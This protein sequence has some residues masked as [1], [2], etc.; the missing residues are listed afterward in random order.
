MPFLGKR[1]LSSFSRS[2]GLIAFLGF[3]ILVFL[4]ACGEK[5]GKSADSGGPPPPVV[6]AQVTPT[7]VPI[8]GEYVARTEA[9]QTV[10]IRSRVDG[11]LEKVLFQEGSQVNAGQLL[12]VIDQRPF[13]AA[14]QEARGSL[15]QVQASLRKAQRDVERFTPLV[16]EDA[17]PQQDLDNAKSAVEYNKASIDR[18]KAGIAKAELDLKF[19]E[20]R[21]PITGIIGKEEVTMGNLV[22]RDQTLL[23]TVSSWDPMRVVF[24]LSE[25]DYLRLSGTHRE[26]QIAFSA[27]Q[28]APFELLMADNAFYPLRGRLSFVDRALN[29]TTGTLKVYVSFPNPERRLRPGMFGRVRVMLEER[30]NALLVPQ[31][32]VQ[33]MQGVDSLLV[34][35]KDN[36]V[37]IRI[38]TLGERY[39]D[40]F[41]VTEGLQPG[42]RVVVE[43]LQNVMPG[44][45]VMPTLES[46]NQERKGG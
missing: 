3:F 31:R 20:I 25:N 45:K 27:S 7:T 37:S 41:M 11:F 16:A 8:F 24:S 22:R 40:A 13:R 21:A 29:L 28:G 35:D 32:A 12:F 1:G 26:G 46:I 43:G 9:R 17:A 39:R 30:P 5:N 18:A 14:L 10:E 19:T 38:V 6:V 2:Q 42:E 34:V 4:T 36:R 33:R 15:A 23:T 44:Q